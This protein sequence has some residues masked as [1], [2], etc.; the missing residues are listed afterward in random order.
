MNASDLYA[1]YGVY[2]D[3]GSSAQYPDDD[4]HSYTTYHTSDGT[5][6]AVVL[7]MNGLKPQGSSGRLQRLY[8][9]CLDDSATEFKLYRD[10]SY[11][12]RYGS[13]GQ[14]DYLVTSI[15]ASTFMTDSSVGDNSLLSLANNEAVKEM[16][17][18]GI[19]QT[20]ESL[21]NFMVRKYGQYKGFRIENIAYGSIAENYN[22]VG[23][24]KSVRYDY[25]VTPDSF[26][27]P[28]LPQPAGE[29]E[30]VTWR[31]EYETP[32][33]CDTLQL[34]SAFLIFGDSM[35][36]EKLIFDVYV[37]GV[38]GSKGPSVKIKWR[39]ENPDTTMLSTEFV[40]PE[41]W[42]YPIPIG[43]LDEQAANVPYAIP[44]E[45]TGTPPDN[46]WVPDVDLI[47]DA[48]DHRYVWGDTQYSDWD[49]GGDYTFTYV[50]ENTRLVS[51]YSDFSKVTYF[52]L[53]KIATHIRVYMR[54]NYHGEEQN[55]IWGD[56]WYVDIPYNYEG[57]A[58][59]VPAMQSNSKLG[60]NYE[61]EVNIIGGLP[62]EDPGDDPDQPEPGIDNDGDESDTGP[63]DPDEDPIDFEDS[64]PEG[65]SGE[66]VLT[67]TYS[68]VG[69]TLANVGGK[70]WSQSYL[71]VM[72][73]Q[74]NPIEN[75]ISVKW[76]PFLE[77][78]T[79]EEIQVGDV[80]FG[81]YAS[82]V[83]T[84]KVIPFTS[85]FKYTATA[86]RPGYLSCSPYT[87]IK[88]HLP[89]CGI[90]QLDASEWLDC[91][92]SGK[93][94]CDLITGDV[95]VIL[96]KDGMPFMSVPGKMGVDIP[97]T[98]SNRVQT[99]ISIA[100]KSL[101]AAIGAAGHII[102]GDYLGAAAEGGNGILS[103]V[104]MDY[105]TQRSGTHSPACSAYEDRSVWIEIIRSIAYVSDGY[106]RGHGFPAHLYRK[107]QQG[108]G[109][110]QMDKRV[111]INVAMTDSENRMLEQIMTSGFYV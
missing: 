37:D 108:Q 27:T 101:S 90:I 51:R 3:G 57:A 70:L 56:L 13:G 61:T 88:L 94:V 18:D 97:L 17:F 78:G 76:Y 36:P 39:N 49:E 38:I 50:N 93:Y 102:S 28:D 74:N 95:L 82:V 30:S 33:E 109:Y 106:K 4:A 42:T 63:Y 16:F 8:L 68:M 103:M 6:A 107:L 84:I 87:M 48:N 100:G 89:Y 55:D 105:T 58:Y 53:D 1:E 75:I 11:A 44:V 2:Y 65:Y 85:S 66:A 80:P 43:G 7:D 46:V 52:G 83:P 29:L 99:E 77:T 45:A 25:G 98:A 23:Y 14:D 19:T 34:L 21:Y 86:N 5:M 40:E 91:T 32:I 67:K 111:E 60:V 54:F 59:I 31:N 10:T 12:N 22:T 71:D 72:K 92:L 73:V 104:G 24:V 96:T 26:Y 47:L 15:A 20:A 110:V 35:I 41:F 9:Y 64:E 81:V 69:T 79:S 62:P